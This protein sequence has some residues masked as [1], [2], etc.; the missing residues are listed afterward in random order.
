MPMRLRAPIIGWALALIVAITG[1]RASADA[2]ASPP[3]PIGNYDASEAGSQLPEQPY[4]DGDGVERSLQEHLGS[5]LVVNFWATWCAPCVEEMPALDALNKALDG[6]GVQVL[7]LSADLKG[8]EAVRP[9]FARHG[10]ETLPV[11]LDRRGRLAQAFG[12]PGLPTTVLIGPGGQEVGRVMGIAAWD[13]PAVV[14]FIENC[15]APPQS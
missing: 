5:G 14:D 10:I 15:L 4:T 3:D 7:T 13:D 6:T 2:C 12:V 8:A 1:E 11:L 9:F